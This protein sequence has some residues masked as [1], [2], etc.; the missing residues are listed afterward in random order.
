MIT[1][2]NKGIT[3]IALILTII[4][5]LILATITTYTGIDTYK[6]SVVYE[7]VSEMQLLQAK[8][9][10]LVQ[11]KTKEEILK[12]G[13]VATY[14]DI[15]HNAIVNEEIITLNIDEA[16]YFTQNDL[17]QVFDIDNAYSDVIINFKTR[18]IIS[19][20]GVEYEGNKYYTQY[21]LPNG[22]TL[23]NVTDEPS[24]RRLLQ[25]NTEYNSLNLSIDGLNAIVT[26]SNIQITNG[27]L[28]Y[29]EKGSEHWINITNYT[30]K[31]NE[32]K[33]NISK[34]GTYEFRL[35][36]NI[37]SEN[38]IETEKESE[39]VIKTTNKPKT[40]M[41]LKYNYGAGSSEW[42]YAQKEGVNYV[43]IP[44]FVYDTNKNIKFI[45]GNSNITTDEIYITNDT[46]TVPEKFKSTQDGTELTGIWIK[47][48]SA[49]QTGLN[50]LMLINDDTDILTEI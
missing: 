37:N 47:T 26:I 41:N 36:D 17:L 32:Y 33:V 29:K 5:T 12:L 48:E 4:I 27:T 40:N 35:Q 39:I 13:T 46:W 6:E 18:E 10:D 23:I 30:E 16:R 44:R 49:Q 28:K 50:L 25:F 38:Y 45:K 22:Q 24:D 3:L 7:F 14:N 21:K 31:G 43:W 34:S 42:A 8:V 15:V 20:K 19:M 1:K 11:N 9:D 2:D